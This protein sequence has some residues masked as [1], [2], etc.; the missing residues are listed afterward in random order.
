MSESGLMPLPR[1][2]R[3]PCFLLVVKGCMNG[4]QSNFARGHSIIGVVLFRYEEDKICTY[5][6]KTVIHEITF[7]QLEVTSH[8]CTGG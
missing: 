6:E 2:Q 1:A 5:A 7:R 3:K 8:V 4:L